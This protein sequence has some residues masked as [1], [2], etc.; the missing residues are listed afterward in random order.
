M[1]YDFIRAFG[2]AFNE[3]RRDLKRR[4]WIRKS[5]ASIHTPF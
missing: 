4:T 2:H 3:F 1:L 5:R